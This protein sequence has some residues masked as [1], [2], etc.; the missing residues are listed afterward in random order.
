MKLDKLLSPI[1]K[2][3]TKD[4]EEEKVAGEMVPRNK[5]NQPETN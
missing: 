2:S 5:N 1:L 4:V 3:L